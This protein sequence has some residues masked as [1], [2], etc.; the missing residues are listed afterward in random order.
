MDS[1]KRYFLHYFLIIFAIAIVLVIIVK[2]H[3][4]LKL[5]LLYFCVVLAVFVV[6]MSLLF[7]RQESV[8]TIN[9]PCKDSDAVY[10]QIISI[11]ESKTDR[12]LVRQ[13]ESASVFS[14]PASKVQLLTKYKRWLTNDIT[15]VKRASSVDVFI[16][17]CYKKHFNNFIEETIE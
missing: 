3:I 9:I 15:V 5:L 11:V 17:Q 12:V 2:P 16:P 7:S 8:T 13:D 14:T 4:S 6:P 10:T 1:F